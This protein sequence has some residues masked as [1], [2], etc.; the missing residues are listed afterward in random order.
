MNRKKHSRMT[1]IVTFFID[2]TVQNDYHK[3]W[4]VRARRRKVQLSA[5]T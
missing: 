1:R 5:L 3:N 4:T 2:E